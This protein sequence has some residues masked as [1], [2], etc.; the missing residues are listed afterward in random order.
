M[1]L[2]SV[3]TYLNVVQVDYQDRR[4]QTCSQLRSLKPPQLTEAE[5]ATVQTV[6]LKPELLLLACLYID[7]MVDASL[8]RECTRPPIL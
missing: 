3:S 8:P 4:E 5:A 1:P 2:P 6:R 7:G